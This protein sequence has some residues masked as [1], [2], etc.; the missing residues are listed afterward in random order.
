MPGPSRGRDGNVD[1]EGRRGEE[2]VGKVK[3]EVGG[4]Q[5][6]PSPRLLM[7]SLC[8]SYLLQGKLPEG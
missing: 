2:G 4:S 3:E 7:L 1:S 8:L 5:G 6:W